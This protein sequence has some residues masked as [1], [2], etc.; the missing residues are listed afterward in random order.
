MRSGKRAG[1]AGYELDRLWTGR[2]H[3]TER[4]EPVAVPDDFPIKRLPPRKA[5]K[6][7]TQGR[8][9]HPARRGRCPSCGE[10]TLR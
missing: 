8:V 10:Q 2:T 6:S 7:P 5:S 9:D 4:P 3:M 1:S